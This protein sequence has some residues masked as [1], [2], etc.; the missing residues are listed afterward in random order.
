MTDTTAAPRKK[1][2]WIY[3]VVGILISLFVIGIALIGSAIFYVRRHINTQ[4]V[5]ADVANAEF[6]RARSRFAGQEPLIEL[7]GEHDAVI[8]RRTA[9]PHPELQTMH[10]LAFDSHEEKLVRV[11]VPFWLLRMMPDKRFRLGKNQ[12]VDFDS[13]RYHLTIDDIE[14]AGPGLLMDGTDPRGGTYVLI[15]TE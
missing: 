6:E 2:T 14:R 7:L 13:E 12:G 4:T 15:W 3:V 5:A 9:P 11:S 10:V 1:R 8:H